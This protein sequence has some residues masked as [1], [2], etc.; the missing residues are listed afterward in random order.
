MDM[1]GAEEFGLVLV[2]VLVLETLCGCVG[3][4][5]CGCVGVWVC[6]W[7]VEEA[8]LRAAEGGTTGSL[9]ERSQ[10]GVASP[11]DREAVRTESAEDGFN[12]ERL[13]DSFKLEGDCHGFRSLATRGQ[14][15]LAPPSQ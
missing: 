1:V 9:P 13:R 5:V 3:V 6:G 8:S 4:W 7:V 10:G 2:L 14:A 11:S 15:C 12:L